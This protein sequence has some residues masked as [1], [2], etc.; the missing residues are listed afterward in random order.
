MSSP[1]TTIPMGEVRKAKGTRPATRQQTGPLSVPQQILEGLREMAEFATSGEPPEKRYTVRQLTLDLG[2]GDYTP[3]KVRATREVFGLSQP[4]FAKFLG[5]DV[6]ATPTLGTGHPLAL[7]SRSPVPGRDERDPRPLAGTD[8]NGGSENPEGR[9]AKRG[10]DRTGW[11]L[12]YS[13]RANPHSNSS[14]LTWGRPC[15]RSQPDSTI[16]R[17]S[18]LVLRLI[19]GKMIAMEA[20]TTQ[21]PASQKE[22]TVSVHFSGRKNEPTRDVSDTR[23]LAGLRENRRTV[24]TS[25]P[26]SGC[27]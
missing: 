4:L 26:K 18:W 24:G 12:L 17:R 19:A 2:P 6:S 1:K 10:R 13:N 23:R 11:K 9:A 7:S 22:C 25:P 16:F 21:T 14:F 5:V 15:Q 8:R 20:T 27:L 3:E